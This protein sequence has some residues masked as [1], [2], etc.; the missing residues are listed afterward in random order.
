MKAMKEEE[1]LKAIRAKCLECSCGSIK[2]AEECEVKTCALYPYRPRM[3]TKPDRERRK[4]KQTTIFE[5]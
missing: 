1:I 2:S 3:P 5:E 4:W